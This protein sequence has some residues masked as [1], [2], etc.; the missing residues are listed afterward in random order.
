MD[1]VTDSPNWVNR[2]QTSLEY[3]FLSAMQGGLGI[4]A[5]LNHWQDGDFATAKQ[6][7]T[8]YKAIR[9]TVQQGDLYRLISPQGDSQRSA[10]LSVTSDRKQAVLFAFL[11]SSTKLDPLPAIQLRGLDP[12]KIY[13]LRRI[14]A[15]PQ[16]GEAPANPQT[17]SGRFWMERG[18]LTDLRGDFQAAGFVLDAAK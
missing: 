18:I 1:W 8:D 11:H 7:V 16:P 2:R 10:T 17:A 6:M 15:A 5:N 3:R 14:G 9:P 13:R 12:A 4:G